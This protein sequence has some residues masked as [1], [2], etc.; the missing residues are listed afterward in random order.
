MTAF[1][2]SGLKYELHMASFRKIFFLARVH[3]HA[4]FPAQSGRSGHNIAGDRWGG[5]QST[6]ATRQRSAQPELRWVKANRARLDGVRRSSVS[7]A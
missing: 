4:L 2:I 7:I 5:L 1:P 3:A 6:L